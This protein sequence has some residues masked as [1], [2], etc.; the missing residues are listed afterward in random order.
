MIYLSHFLDKETP[1]YGGE[2]EAVKVNQ[3]RAIANGDTSN[4]IAVSFPV[5]IGTHIDFPFHFSADGKTA[6]DYPASFWICN[7]VGVMEGKIEEVPALIFQLPEDIELLIFKTAFAVHRGEEIYWKDQPVIPAA[8][9]KL[10]RNRFPKLRIFGFDMISLTSKLNREEGR[11][12]HQQFLL[13]EDILVLEDMKLD[14]L[15]F[16]PSSVI[17]APLQINN[18]DGAPCNIIAV[19]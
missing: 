9:A 18:A 5:H 1:C 8:Y 10:F 13:H 2:P 11:K 7:K 15:D 6:S 12:A 3:I 16:T 19:K 17:I 14:E 4:N